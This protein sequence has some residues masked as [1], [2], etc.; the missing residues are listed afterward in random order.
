MGRCCRWL[1]KPLIVIYI[2][3]KKGET[4]VRCGSGAEPKQ[5]RAIS[6]IRVAGCID[7]LDGNTNTPACI[8][9]N[10]RRLVTCCRLL[11]AFSWRFG[12]L[13]LSMCKYASSYLILFFCGLCDTSFSL[14]LWD[15]RTWLSEERPYAGKC[16]D[17]LDVKLALSFPEL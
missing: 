11:G 4:Y 12:G 10:S 6:D 17:G 15:G 9:R 16:Q 3:E 13:G 8:E 14:S 1:G 7:G 5:N 2:C